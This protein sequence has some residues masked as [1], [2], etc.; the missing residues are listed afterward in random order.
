VFGGIAK[1]NADWLLRGEPLLTWF[2]AHPGL[3]VFLSGR[4][5]AFALAWGGAVFDLFVVFA[6]LHK[7]SRPIAFGA[8]TAFHV[9]NAYLFDIG[10]FPWLMIALTTVFLE[11][12]WARRDSAKLEAKGQTKGPK[13]T[14]RAVV[15]CVGL[16]VLLQVLVPLRHFTYEGVTAWTDEGHR[17]AWR[18]KLRHKTGSLHLFARSAECDPNTHLSL[19][20]PRALLDGR[21]LEQALREPEM[22]RQ[23][24]RHLGREAERR[25]G[26]RVEVFAE[27][28]IALNGRCAQPLIRPD[29][30]FAHLDPGVSCA[31]WTVP[32]ER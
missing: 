8:A 31:S 2:R 23:L 32:L 15:F 1:L 14:S 24:A 12:G 11:P 30:D 16:H 7:R 3:P 18:M 5:A 20:E 6:L 17:F 21:Q 29:V 27:T 13:P 10:I 28:S 22:V 26:C 25:Y 4:V 9:T 19:P